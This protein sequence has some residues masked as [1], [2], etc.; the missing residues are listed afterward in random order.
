MSYLCLYPYISSPH[1]AHRNIGDSYLVCKELPLEFWIWRH[2][3]THTP[4]M[5][6]VIQFSQAKMTPTR[7]Q[8]GL[9][10]QPK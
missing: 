9:N 7:S 1:R 6:D 3:H 5:C 10:A 2:Q 8:N 4:T